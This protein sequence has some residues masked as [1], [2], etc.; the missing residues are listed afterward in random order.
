[1]NRH[2]LA[3]KTAWRYLFARKSHSAVNAISIV[4]V[5]GIAIATMAM[6][7]V[8]SVYNGFQ[9]FLGQRAASIVPDVEVRPARGK[10]MAEADSLVAALR[11]MPQTAVA[12]PVIDDNM[13]VYYDNRMVPVRVLGVEEQP[14][15]GATGIRSLL[16]A[17]STYRL[18]SPAPVSDSGGADDVASTDDAAD[19]MAA[20]EFSEAD[21]MVDAA[22]LYAGDEEMTDPGLDTEPVYALLS[23][24]VVSQLVGT[25][26]PQQ[27]AAGAEDVEVMFVVP[28]RTAAISVSNPENAFLVSD[29]AVGGT[30]LADKA[31]FGS[32]MAIVDLGMARDMLEYTT[33]ASAVY[34]KAAPGIDAAALASAVR[35]RLGDSYTVTDRDSQLSL[36]FNMMRIEKWFTFLLLSFILVIAS[37]NIISTLSMLIVDKREGISVMRRLG[38]SKSFVGEVF[39][40]ESCYVCFIGTLTGLAAGLL[41]C[42]LQMRYGFITIPNAADNLII[43]RYPVAVRMADL[44]WLLVPSAAIAV[45]T[46]LVSSRFARRSPASLHY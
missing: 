17:G 15:A 26:S 45:V 13:L 24:D 41:L 42:W 8:L 11:S 39:S 30:I 2:A 35:K 16:S 36:H 14:Y 10:V 5:C 44:L 7:C 21:L 29:V 1:M 28:R 27:T 12:T 22:T 20:G 43:D 3:A 33:E 31:N 34:L 40:W 25:P 6:V 4:S 46:A 9:D 38:A 23:D 18:R 37:F 32:N 19:L